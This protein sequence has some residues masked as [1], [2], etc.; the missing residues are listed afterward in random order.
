MSVWF[1]VPVVRNDARLFYCPNRQRQDCGTEIKDNP[2]S[3]KN[4]AHDEVK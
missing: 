2:I 4:N 3:I 1:I